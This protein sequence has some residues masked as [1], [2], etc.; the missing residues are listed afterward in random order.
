M[1][2]DENGAELSA[3]SMAENIAA[4]KRRNAV[5]GFIAIPAA[6]LISVSLGRVTAPILV[7]LI[8]VNAALAGVHR[9][10]L[11]D[12]SRN[13]Y[14]RALRVLAV[15][16]VAGVFGMGA[17]LFGFR[18]TRAL[19][20]AKKALY[21]HGVNDYDLEA[22]LLPAEL[23]EYCVDYS[24]TTKGTAVAQDYHADLYLVFR[25]DRETLAKYDAKMETLPGAEKMKSGLTE[26]SRSSVPDC[27]ASLPVHVFHALDPSLK[28]GLDNAIIYIIHDKAYEKGCMLDYDSGLA[29]FWE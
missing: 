21:V 1:R 22:K 16:S 24:L 13:G 14:V 23:P 9:L 29:V 4:W 5:I 27:P 10:S 12:D 11:Y 26:D 18:R 15:L 25:T 6:I 19:Y 3:R 7:A 17:L 2:T 8:L 28:K 20:G